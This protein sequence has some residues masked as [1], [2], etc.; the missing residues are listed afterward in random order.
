MNETLFYLFGL[1]A[2]FSL[3]CSLV[4]I[5]GCAKLLINA[6]AKELSTHTIE[7]RDPFKDYGDELKLD[8]TEDGKVTVVSEGHDDMYGEETIDHMN[9]FI[10]DNGVIL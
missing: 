8:K 10:N 7:F 3:I 6:R 2:L 1:M 4:A 9:K 5:H